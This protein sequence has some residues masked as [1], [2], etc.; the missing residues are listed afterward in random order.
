[1]KMKGKRL[2]ATILAITL[3]LTSTTLAFGDTDD[4]AGDIVFSDMPDNW[5]TEA[6]AAAVDN[7]LLNGYQ[8]GGKILI[9]PNKSLTRAEMATIVNHAFGANVAA[10]ISG[11]TDVSSSDWFAG[12]M[13]KAVQMKTFALDSKMR[14]NDKITRQE[15]FAVLSRAFKT[16][17]TDAAYLALNAFSDKA[18]ISKWAMADLAGLAEEGYIQG[19]GG[20][21][22]PLDY[23][24]RA[25]MATVMDKLVKQYID[26]AGTVTSVAASGNI[27]IRAEGVTLQNLTVK[28]DLIIG[29]G[30]GE[31]NAILDNV[32][33]EGRTVVRGGGV[34]SFIIKG[35]S[36]I[37]KVIVSKTTGE[38][39]VDVEGSASVDVVYV[40]DG[41]DDVIVQGTIGSLEVAGNEVNVTATDAKITSAVVSGD[42]SKITLGTGSTIVD[43]SIAGA[44]SAIVANTGSI[45]STLIVSGD[46]ASVSG[47]GTIKTVVVTDTGDNAAVTTP[48]TK[49]TVAS[50]AAGVTVGGQ[51]V[52][53]GST[54]TSNSTG[55][56]ATVIQPGSSGSS[57]GGSHNEKPVLYRDLSKNYMKYVD[58]DFAYNIAYTLAYDEQYGG[59]WGFRTA[60]SDYEHA[61]ADYLYNVMEDVGLSDIEKV[62]VTVDK[63]QFNSASLQ[64]AGEDYVITPASYATSGTDADGLTAEIV[65]VG[66]GTAAEYSGLDVKGKIVLAGVDQMNVA[67]IDAVMAEAYYQGASAIITYAV[68]GYARIT[69]SAIN[70]QDVCSKD[71]MPCVSISAKDGSYLAGKIAEGSNTATLTVDNEI[72]IGDGVSYNVI[73]KIT[74][75]SSAQQIIVSGH[76]DKY[77]NGFQDDSCAIALV[78]SMAK[79]MKDSG[80][81]PENDI[82]FVCHGAEE[83]GA[84][85]SQ[86]D[87]TTGAWRMINEVHPEWADKT[88]AMLNF[89]LPA[90][91]A[92]EDTA[93][94]STVPEFNTLVKTF[95]D[96]SGL[97]DDID[98][99][100]YPKGI[101][102]TAV[103]VQTM[104]DGISY[105]NAGVP[106]LLN[107]CTFDSDWMAQ[108][109][110]TI[111]DDAS[112]YSPEVMKL[113]LDMYG[114]LAIYI[115]QSPALMLDF[116]NT[117]TALEN[118]LNVDLADAAGADTAAYLEALGQL[119]TAASSLHE[120]A[121]QINAAYA[122]AYAN[123]D[124][125]AMAKLRAE[126]TALNTLQLKAFKQVQDQFIGI[127]T[128]WDVI[129]KHEGASDNIAI[130]TEIIN[131]LNNGQITN[132]EGTGA[133][134]I[135]WNLNGAL[136]Y[137]YYL[138]TREVVDENIAMLFDATN[139]GN[140]FW[141]KDK[142]VPITDTADG[143][144]AASVGDIAS[145]LT[146]YNQALIDQ[147]LVLKNFIQSETEGMISLTELI[148]E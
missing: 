73:G 74:G 118:A 107:K 128:V 140:T 18:S 94:I 135:A 58:E 69:D 148:T 66:M 31:G 13:A 142:V 103:E 81:V 21:L 7:G 147:Q 78:L 96:T 2:L 62:P 3:V 60:G 30:V 6:L 37:G 83:W 20:K 59:E 91:Y 132:A 93:Y 112:T 119:K 120:K 145:A 57:G 116:S 98:T 12:E 129:I 33:V 76:Y 56:G 131:A 47:T 88:I 97:L 38:V 110:H 115:D 22:N 95:V 1:M 84:S 32:A 124:Q 130:L 63:W 19:A 15:A 9:K 24:T 39:R 87:W 29:D 8:I 109:Y 14:P 53:A 86:Q 28:G 108:R 35:N 133:L 113:N 11:A 106:Y 122:E 40:D 137:R 90:F 61:A 16:T 138:F 121:E 54:A 77:F 65:N 25:E 99:S 4:I 55:T 27:M 92:G 23:I 10:S 80:Y 48:N 127:V 52:P 111:Y 43:C 42:A 17:S 67:W 64:L 101:N 123:E 75:K 44:S 143:L 82:V 126:G 49:T 105:R 50:G 146:V 89:E 134:D 125:V 26:V 100:I 41:S 5:S 141:G 117:C 71:L 102:S 79:A 139:P 34:N 46:K 72:S 136:E 104:E 51:N 144:A 70:I 85:G 36:N 68:D 114:A 45:V